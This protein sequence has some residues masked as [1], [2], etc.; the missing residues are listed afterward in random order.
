VAHVTDIPGIMAHGDSRES[1]AKKIQDALSLAL[2]S[3]AEAKE[4][5]PAPRNLP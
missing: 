5:P 1:A 2:E 3:Y 4:K